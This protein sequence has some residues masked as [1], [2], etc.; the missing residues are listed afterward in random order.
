VRTT[1][2]NPGIPRSRAP[3]RRNSGRR[4]PPDARKVHSDTIKAL[5]AATE[6]INSRLNTIG[7]ILER[8]ATPIHQSIA[9]QMGQSGQGD[10]A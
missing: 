1:L 5:K 9:A 3:C 2:P 8:E 7:E 4:V 6:A 10:R